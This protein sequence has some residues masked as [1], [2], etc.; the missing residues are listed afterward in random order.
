MSAIVTRSSTRR[1]PTRVASHTSRSA[2]ADPWNV[3][4]SGR[5]P[6][7]SARGP[8]TARMTSAIVISD[9]GVAIR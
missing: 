2:V 9:A 5:T 3:S 7:T 4:D 1:S 8:S 6:R